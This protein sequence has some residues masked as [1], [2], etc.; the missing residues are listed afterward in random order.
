[1]KMLVSNK[2]AVYLRIIS[3]TVPFFEECPAEAK[4]GWPDF[5]C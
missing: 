3:R 4:I 2:W 1:M 5:F